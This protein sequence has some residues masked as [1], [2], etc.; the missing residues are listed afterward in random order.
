MLEVHEARR[1]AHERMKDLVQNTQ[2]ICG[3]LNPDPT[4]SE[5]A[6]VR[7]T[8]AMI[9]QLGEAYTRARDGLAM[10]REAESPKPTE[11]VTSGWQT[12]SG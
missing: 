10:L 3:E 1:V 12:G 6:P 5:A 9:G 11:A 8:G 7:E 2:G 4:G